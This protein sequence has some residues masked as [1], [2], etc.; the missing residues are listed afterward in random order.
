MGHMY[1][2]TNFVIMDLHSICKVRHQSTGTCECQD[3]YESKRQLFGREITHTDYEV[4][5]I[6]NFSLGL[7]FITMERTY[8]PTQTQLRIIPRTNGDDLQFEYTYL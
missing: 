1:V 4:I 5:V 3:G 2:N 6:T 8:I 7:L